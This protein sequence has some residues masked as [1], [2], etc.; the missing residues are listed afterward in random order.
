M[1][2]SRGMT[3]ANV[4]VFNQ[5]L[6]LSTSICTHTHRYSRYISSTDTQNVISLSLSLSLSLFLPCNP[7]LAFILWHSLASAMLY[8]LALVWVS[9]AR[10]PACWGHFVTILQRFW[11]NMSLGYAVLQG[12]K[13]RN[14]FVSKGLRNLVT[15]T[16]S[17]AHPKNKE[18]GKLSRSFVVDDLSS[19]RYVLKKLGRKINRTTM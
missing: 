17:E 14:S 2:I 13:M 8:F 10:R 19:A 9:A 16:T 4:C 6:H 1:I 18:W 3:S 5:C 15:H 12:L 11:L 7:C